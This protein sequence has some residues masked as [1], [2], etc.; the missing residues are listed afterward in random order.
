MK[1]GLKWMAGTVRLVDAQA[2]WLLALFLLACGYAFAQ[3]VVPDLGADPLGW[4]RM[5][6]G[7]PVALG[8]VVFG[9]VETWKRNAARREPPLNWQ[10]WRWWTL[11]FLIG[12]GGSVA[13]SCAA[14]LLPGGAPLTLADLPTALLNGVLAGVVAI[15]GRDGARTVLGWIWPTG[16]AGSTGPATLPAGQGEGEPAAPPASAF[17]AAEAARAPL[18]LMGGLPDQ[19]VTPER[20]LAPAVLASLRQVLAESLPEELTAAQVSE[21]AVE[22]AP[23]IADLAD[24]RAYLSAEDQEQVLTVVQDALSGTDQARPV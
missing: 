7:N 11:A 3:P 24:G 23:V 19:V 18:G 17:Q 1:R 15:A 21:L 13:L 20:A 4:L 10:P 5:M 9:L 16:A 6:A 22:L 8:L 2:R 12:M 14:G